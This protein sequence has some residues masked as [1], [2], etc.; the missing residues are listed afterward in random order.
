IELRYQWAINAVQG[1]RALSSRKAAV[2]Y[3][4]ARST[5]DTRL[6]GVKSRREAHEHQH[7]LSTAQ[8]GVLVEWVKV[9]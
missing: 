7:V 4:V 6:K 1:R 9:L 2:L 8:E 3:R 5:L